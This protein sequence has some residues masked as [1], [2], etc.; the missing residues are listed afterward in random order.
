MD[1]DARI[2]IVTGASAG[3]GEATSAA[4]AARGLRVVMAC[5]DRGRAEQAAA[6]IRARVPSAKLDVEL[7]DLASLASVRAAVAR[8]GAL[9]R[10]D[11]LV[12][13]AGTTTKVRE[14]TEDGLERTLAVDTLGPFALTVPLL[15][16]MRAG[17]RIVQLAGIYHRRGELDLDDLS[18]ASRRWS[19]LAANNQ[20]QLARVVLAFELARRL[21]PAQVTVNAVHPGAVRTNAQKDAPRWAQLLMRTVARP[22][23]VDAD[24]GAEPV[25]R[26]AL[27]PALARVSGR[28]FDRM[29]EA[30]ANPIAHDAALGR[31]LWDRACALTGVS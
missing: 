1:D 18:F 25:V 24:R 8:L 22:F 16:R 19:M 26:L 2:A 30:A 31:A 21:D 4:L 12:L 29:D 6:R 13:N 3:I 10:I 9:P 14:L 28:F 20:A 27:D 7:V 17:A 5:R 23:F 11:V 15:D